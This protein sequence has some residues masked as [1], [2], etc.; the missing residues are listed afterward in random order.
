MQSNEPISYVGMRFGR[1]VA[2]ERT[3]D[4]INPNGK[5]VV[6]YK[7]KLLAISG[8]NTVFRI[9]KDCILYGLI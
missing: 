6:V 2:L 5:R 8:E 9:K 3:D 1:L 7:E 4:A